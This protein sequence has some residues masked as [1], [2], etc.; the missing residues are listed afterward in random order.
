MTLDR[1]GQ[2]LTEMP[3]EAEVRILRWADFKFK[4]HTTIY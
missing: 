1:I 2:L 4:K 3:G